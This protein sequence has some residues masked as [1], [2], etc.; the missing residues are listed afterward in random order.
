MPLSLKVL[1]AMGCAIEKGKDAWR[2]FRIPDEIKQLYN[3][4]L[5]CKDD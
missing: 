3:Y 4:I 2:L 1:S 5:K